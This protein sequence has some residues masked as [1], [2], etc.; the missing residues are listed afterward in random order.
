MRVSLSDIFK[1]IGD[2]LRPLTEG[3][4][5]LNAGHV[6]VCGNKKEFPNVLVGLCLQ[7]SYAS[8]SPH[9]IE[10]K[11]GRNTSEWQ[12]K[13]TCKAGEGAMCKHIIAVL[14]QRNR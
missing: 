5:V 11:L 1:Y 3:E 10:I 12:A 8:G 2:R 9:E 6:I 13:C 7:S 14:L 4:E